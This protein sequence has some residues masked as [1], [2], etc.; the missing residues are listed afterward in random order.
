MIPA[1]C[2]SFKHYKTAPTLHLSAIL[3]LLIFISKIQRRP[4]PRKNT[5][6][7]TAHCT[8]TATLA[9]L[10]YLTDSQLSLAIL[11]FQSKI[12]ENPDDPII[13]GYFVPDKEVLVFS[14]LI[15]AHAAH[16]RKGLHSI[17]NSDL[18]ATFIHPDQ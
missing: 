15:R 2:T 8:S 1:G 11:K 6:L 12:D 18:S 10:A 17:I 3:I 5:T 13:L 16:S 14:R 9:Y 7:R 4:F